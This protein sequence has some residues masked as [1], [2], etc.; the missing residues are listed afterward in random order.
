MQSNHARAVLQIP[1]VFAEAGL[2][3]ELRTFLERGIREHSVTSEAL[4]WLCK[5]RAGEWRE[6]IT[7]DL[8]G[9]ILSALERDQHN[10]NSRGSKLRDLLLDDR[11]L[12]PDMFSRRRR[13]AW[14]AMPCAA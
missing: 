14:P 6:L 5:E 1:R 12:I 8:L 7:P 11:D 2:Q 4:V 10:E 9:A 13:R 3:G